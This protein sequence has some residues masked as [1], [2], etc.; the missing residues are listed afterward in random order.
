M[1]RT[2]KVVLGLVSGLAGTVFLFWLGL[3]VKPAPFAAYKGSPTAL[4]TVPLPEGLPAPVA[5]FYRAI[6][7]ERVPIIP[8]AVISGRAAIRPV[9]PAIGGLGV[10]ITAL[11]LE[12]GLRRWLRSSPVV[13]HAKTARLHGLTVPGKPR[14]RWLDVAVHAR[15][16][17]T[18]H[19]APG[20]L[21]RLVGGLEQVMPLGGD[22]T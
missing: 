13:S 20:V 17:V 14:A 7:G 4:E 8:S 3:K 15:G 19:M 16:S 22:F 11:T 10:A 9:G 2:S 5:R 1:T 18:H 12:L 6:Y 21:Y